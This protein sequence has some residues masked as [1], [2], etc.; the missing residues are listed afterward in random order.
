MFSSLALRHLQFKYLKMVQKLFYPGGLAAKRST[1][2][3]AANDWHR[4][5]TTRPTDFHFLK[6][7]IPYSYHARVIAIMK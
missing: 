6:D 5:K 2:Q 3:W 7:L 4:D 1:L